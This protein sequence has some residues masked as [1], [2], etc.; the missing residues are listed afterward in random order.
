MIVEMLDGHAA[1]QLRQ[2]AE[3]IDVV[4]RQ[5]E[6][7][8]LR[9]AGIGHCRLDAIGV[10]ATG[11]AGV[12]QQCFSGGRHKQR[13]LAALRVDVI[14]G[15]RLGRPRLGVGGRRGK[16]EREQERKDGCCSHGGYSNPTKRSMIPI[17]LPTR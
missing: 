17:P 7:I 3:V 5:H 15:K 9:D 13:R 4:V 16:D 1:G 6:V 12:H 10:A 11:I 2:A 8:D 14:D